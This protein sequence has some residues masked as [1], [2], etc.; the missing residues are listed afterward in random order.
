[1]TTSAH[2]PAQLTITVDT[3]LA[4][5][6]AWS[7][8][9]ARGARIIVPSG[10]SITS[11]TFHES[12]TRDGTYVACYDD[13]ATT[14]VAITLTGLSAGRSYPLPAKLFACRYLKM[15]GNADGSVIVLAK[16]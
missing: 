7:I 6:E 4:D 12:N 9:D 10:S 13:T 5:C 2:S 15:V 16:G 8:G 3:N 14:P 1:M 11:L